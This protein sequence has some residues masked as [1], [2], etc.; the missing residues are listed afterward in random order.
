MFTISGTELDQWRSQALAEAI[1]ISIETY[2]VDWLLLELTDLDRLALKLSTYKTQ[3]EVSLRI[4]FDQ[5]QRLWQQRIHDRIPI[6]HL[7]GHSHW[8]QF[9]FKV[10]PDVLIPRPE[11]ELIIDLVREAVE[12]HPHLA[13]G[14]WVDL[15]TGS[16]AIAIGLADALPQATIHA[17]DL[18]SKALA[19]A[20]NNAQ[21]YGYDRR[22]HFHQG[23]WFEPIAALQGQLAGIVSNP[24]YI[25]TATIS[26]LQP[27]V[28][29]HEPHLALD[30]GID[31]LTDIRYLV[32]TGQQFLQPG[33]IW[34]VEMMQGQGQSVSKLLQQT[35]YAKLE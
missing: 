35:N 32:T 23:R 12:P 16:G 33:G 31:G 19:I 3:P 24:P 30:G 20:R 18:S 34:I 2:E 5:L 15:G 1:A 17:V 6:Q 13:A 28:Q 21:T 9:T 29:Q 8:R 22:I 7:I 26:T 4:S 25:P 27:E 11:T 14:T 10:S